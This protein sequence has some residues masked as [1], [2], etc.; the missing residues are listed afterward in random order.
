MPRNSHPDRGTGR[1]RSRQAHSAE[2]R[3]CGQIWHSRLDGLSTDF[4]TLGLFEAAL[5]SRLLP[6]FHPGAASRRQSRWHCGGK[7]RSVLSRAPSSR[8]SR[9]HPAQARTAEAV[10]RCS[11]VVGPA[12]PREERYDHI[13]ARRACCA[14]RPA[15]ESCLLLLCP[16]CEQTRHAGCGPSARPPCALTMATLHG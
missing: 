12:G 13:D 5:A 2:L 7:S 14:C 1:G 11:T 10:C 16:S 6:W 4:V 3:E 15:I 9:L 8:P